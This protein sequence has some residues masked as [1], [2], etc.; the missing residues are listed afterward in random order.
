MIRL[1]KQLQ[2]AA[3]IVG[4]I[5]LPQSSDKNKSG[6]VTKKELDTL[7]KFLDNL[8][9]SANIDIEFTR[10][11]LDR[12]NDPRNKEQITTDELRSLFQ[13]TYQKYRKDLTKVDW[14]AVINDISTDINVPFVLKWDAK[15]KE[16]DLV[17]KT[18][19]R[20]KNFKTSNTKL[21]V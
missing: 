12:V 15:N 13:K 14:Q 11:F 9:K 16:L 19:M 8:F 10:H 4:K 21:K 3:K 1:Q 17:A 5:D 20:K 2:E 18:T 7:E 6:T